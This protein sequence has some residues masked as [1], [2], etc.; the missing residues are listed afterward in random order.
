MM[1]DIRLNMLMMRKSI[2]QCGITG[3]RL[4]VV[5]VQSLPALFDSITVRLDNTLREVQVFP[6]AERNVVFELQAAI[7]FGDGRPKANYDQGRAF[8]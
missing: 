5:P 2:G 7:E 3:M 8:D 6:Y 4:G 1:L